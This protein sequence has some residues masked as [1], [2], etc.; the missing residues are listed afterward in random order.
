MRRTLLAAILFIATAASTASAQELGVKAGINAASVTI[1]DT[2]QIDPGRRV[3][4]VG[5]L[6]ARSPEMRRF[7]L[8]AEVLFSMKGTAYKEDPGQP[9]EEHVTWELNY[10]E[11]PLG[12]L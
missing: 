8:Q 4:L 7:S 9:D 1:P 3:A 10:L 2:A 5:G 6:F 11:L 12:A